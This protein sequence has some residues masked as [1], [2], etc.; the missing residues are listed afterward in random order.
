MFGYLFAFASSLFFTL[1][2]IPRK[3]STVPA[4]VFT[5]LMGTGFFIGSLVLFLARP[6]LGFQETDSPLLGLALLA[7]AIWATGFVNFIKAIDYLGL[8]RSNQWKNLQGPVGVL[9]S[10][11]ILAEY[12]TTNWVLALLAGLAV[13][14]S[15]LALN[16]S[17]PDHDHRL[18]TRGIYHAAGSSLAFGSVAVM[19][20]Y[21][22][23][24]V[25]VLNQQLVWSFGIA[26]SMLV[27]LLIRRQAGQLRRLSRKNLVLGLSAGLLYLGASFCMLES[28]RYLPGAIAFTIIQ[29]SAV[30][31]IA[32]GIL[33]FHEIDARRSAGR[34]VLGL[35]L[36][37]AGIALLAVA[38]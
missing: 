20:K 13:F 17:R 5:F 11:V 25:G 19:N 9:L 7:G 18:S 38:K 16:I 29:L 27:Y 24:H 31:T 30:W 37:V 23:M 28:F 22:S 15:A 14:A 36:A 6:A 34:I 21:M 8:A 12:A 4:T 2:V 10:L 26:L 3:L 32:V 33:V 35:A 1:Y